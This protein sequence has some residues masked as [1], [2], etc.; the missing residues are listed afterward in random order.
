M[1]KVLVLVPVP[2][3]REGLAR[4]QAQLA[5][6]DLVGGAEFEFRA[7]KF[8][9]AY[10]DSHHDLMLAEI[11]LTDA[12]AGAQAEGFDAVCVDTM[13]DSAVKVLRSL[14]D[15]PVI[16][17]GKI[18]FLTA[19]MLG[20]RFSVLTL[21]KPWAFG[22][23]EM[24]R[25]M[26]IADRCASIRWPQ[27]VEPD[28]ENLLEAKEETVLPKLLQAAEVCLQDGAD[29]LCL[30]STTMHAAHSYLT[31]RLAVPVINPGPLSYKMIELMLALG[32]RHSPAAHP[33]PAHP[34]LGIIAA[35]A[36]AAG[37]A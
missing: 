20:D 19:L 10:F 15:I 12:G 31:A 18:S 1:R 8:G 2:V 3:D 23:E 28:L 25:E 30:G 36:A 14:L 7:V 11:A 29:V 5:E 22:Y 17:P 35:M 13:S 33:R 9:P 26:G 16:G 32:L 6:V 34:Q 4:R 27:G 37:N 24:L 21:W